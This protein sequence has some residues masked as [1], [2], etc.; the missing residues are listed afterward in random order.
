MVILQKYFGKAKSSV[1][2]VEKVKT[3]FR[4]TGALQ[5]A[6]EL[7]KSKHSEAKSILQQAQPSLEKSAVSALEWIADYIIQREY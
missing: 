4:D 2:G 1:E 3:V 5:Y 7:A 6:L